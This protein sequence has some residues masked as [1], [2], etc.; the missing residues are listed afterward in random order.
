MK[1]IRFVFKE[2]TPSDAGGLYELQVSRAEVTVSLAPSSSVGHPH[3]HHHHHIP[4][5]VL[6]QK[7]MSCDPDKNAGS[8]S[9]TSS[10]RKQCSQKPSR[11]IETEFDQPD[12]GVCCWCY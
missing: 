9:N 8:R 5:T 1:Q 12:S 11:V 10:R 4:R 6:Q 3:H 2:L 7:G